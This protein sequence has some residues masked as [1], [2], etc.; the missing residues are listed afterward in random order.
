MKKTLLAIGAVLGLATISNAQ[1]FSEN[2]ST[3]QAATWTSTQMPS[4]TDTNYW[5]IYT[6]QS[7]ASQGPMALS[8]SWID[9]GSA[10]GAALT[11]DNLLISPAI[12]MS[13]ITGSVSLSFKVGSP[14]STASGFYEEFMS[15]YVVNDPMQVGS[16]TPIYD[17]VLEGGEQMYSYSFDIS[18]MAAGQASVYL[19]FRHHNCTDEN[20]ILLD[21]IVVTNGGLGVEENTIS[22]SVYPNPATDVL[23]ISIGEE[24]TSFTLYTTEGKVAAT[25]AG[26]SVDV[27]ALNAGMYI[28]EAVTV[29]GKVARGNFAKK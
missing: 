11:P 8:Q 16:A 22:S 20:F 2:W 26:T 21:D 7:F 9:D 15:V 12:D 4:D 3:A 25:S 24:T 29:S 1:I 6:V 27:S 13:S 17:Q 28:Y 5:G 10:S 23:N 14:E 18:S 19:I